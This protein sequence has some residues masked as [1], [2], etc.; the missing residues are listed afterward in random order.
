MINA[1]ILD[2]LITQEMFTPIITIFG[3][4]ASIVIIYVIAK[5]II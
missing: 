5:K 3:I 4:F 1:T 2:K